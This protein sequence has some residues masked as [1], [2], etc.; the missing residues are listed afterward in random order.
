[1]ELG[2]RIQI[3]GSSGSGKSTFA[4]RL[5]EI[6]G[7][8]YYEG[9]T[10]YWRANW[11]APTNEEFADR[12]DKALS[13]EEWIFDGNYGS[14]SEF[15]SQRVETVIILNYSFWL[16]MKRL[17]R[18][19]IRDV[20]SKKMMYGHSQ[21]TFRAAFTGKMGLIPYTIRTFRRRLR[22]YD[23]LDANPGHIQVIRFRHPCEA[24]KFLTDLQ[25]S[26][27]K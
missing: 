25:N 23:E 14:Q 1:M 13:G 11:T 20:S 27:P 26:V 12:L 15:F 6:T 18:R 8:P 5:S 10:I 9:D 4:K 22:Q 24:D 19:S 7:I 3:K 17:L 21:Q 2:R 16:I